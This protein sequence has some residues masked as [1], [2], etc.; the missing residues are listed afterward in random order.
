MSPYERI[1]EPQGGSQAPYLIFEEIP[2]RFNQFKA[3]FFGE[4]PDVVV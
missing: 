2:E 4:T 3:K 1:G